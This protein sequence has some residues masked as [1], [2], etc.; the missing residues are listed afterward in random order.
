MESR[1]PITRKSSLLLG[2]LQ[3]F[4]AISGIAGGIGLVL[5]P[6]GASLGFTTAQLTHAPFQDYL[7]PGLTLLFIIGV[8]NL[9]GSVASFLRYRYTGELS[10]F[11]GG[12][13]AMWIIMQVFWLGLV[14]WL[15][16][17]Y[18]VLGCGE[19][20]LGWRMRRNLP[21]QSPNDNNELN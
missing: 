11:L 8:G 21:T 16:P 1:K 18:F 14:S 17:L 13:L 4:I 9:F 6:N 12:F 3:L 5:E 10:V 20:L 19:L 2:L 15:Q 7:V